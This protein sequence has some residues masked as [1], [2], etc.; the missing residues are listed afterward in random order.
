[1]RIARFFTR[2]GT[3]PYD[4]IEFRTALSEIK[5]PDGSVVFELDDVEV[6]VS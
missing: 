2:E 5:N 6:P 3:S 1:M 4:G